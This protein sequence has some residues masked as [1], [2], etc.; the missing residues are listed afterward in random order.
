MWLQ[1]KYLGVSTLLLAMLSGCGFE[2]VYANRSAQYTEIA[3][4]L[5]AIRVETPRGKMGELLKARLEDHFN[6]MNSPAAIAYTLKVKV[7]QRADP[8][9]IR[10]DGTASRFDIVVIS[11]FQLIRVGDNRVVEKGTITRSSSYNVSDAD[12]YATYVSQNDATKRVMTEVAEDY[13]MRIG[14]ALARLKQR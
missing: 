5:A 13:K 6:P 10:A 11:P 9:L 3:D 12:D 14:A 4:H 2:P 8:S 1:L 7:E